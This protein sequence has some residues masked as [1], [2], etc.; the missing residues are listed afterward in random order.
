[1]VHL[2]KKKQRGKSDLYASWTFRA[3]RPYQ[4][5]RV[6]HIHPKFF[7]FEFSKAI[8]VDF[9]KYFRKKPKDF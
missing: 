9:Q 1:M 3:E 2:D 6:N 5:R 4:I 7:C 8:C